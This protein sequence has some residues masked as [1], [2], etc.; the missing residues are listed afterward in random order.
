M[1][2]PISGTFI[3]EITYDIPS[4]NW[5]LEQWRQELDTMS[6]VGIDTLIVIRGGF[7]GKC[8]FP[9]EALSMPAD[10]LDFAGFLFREAAERKMAVYFGLYISDIDWGKGDYKREIG[11][12]KPF[13]AEALN[14]YGDI[15]SFKGWYLPHETGREELHITELFQGLSAECKDRSPDKKVMI[16]PFFMGEGIFDQPLSPEAHFEEWNR[17]LERNKDLDICAYQDGTAPMA[18][19]SDYYRQAAELCRL[20]GLEHWVN[21]ETFERDVRRQY[22]PIPFQELQRK[23]A[24]HEEYAEKMITFEFSHFLSPNSIY[25]S[26]R[27]L[28]DRY[29]ERY[30][31]GK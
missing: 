19:M 31:G 29:V 6:G 4:S 1:S 21:V 9:S 10:T 5:S 23:I 12:N 13:I 28:F 11:L 3:D 22:Y 16:S 15:P 30:G 14:R 20:H 25:P 7:E 8:T 24:K 17:I 26:A 2:Y 27:N 18:R